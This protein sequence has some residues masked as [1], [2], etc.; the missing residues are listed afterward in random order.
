MEQGQLLIPIKLVQQFVTLEY[1]ML[2]KAAIA[3]Y[4]YL[5]RVVNFTNFM[6]YPIVSTKINSLK[7]IKLVPVN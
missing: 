3:C 6:A 2:G 4:S 1:P 7:F 5:L